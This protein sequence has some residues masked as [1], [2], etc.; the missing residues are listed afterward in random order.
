MSTI[1]IYIEKHQC[2]YKL[3]NINNFD[4]SLKII[5]QLFSIGDYGVNH[6]EFI[7]S[8]ILR[9]LK[10]DDNLKQ[11][12]INM[13]MRNIEEINYYQ[14]LKVQSTNEID[15]DLLCYIAH[16]TQW[17]EFNDFVQ[18]RQKIVGIYNKDRYVRDICD[19]V[20]D[21]L[22]DDWEDTEFYKLL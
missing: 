14:N 16:A 1:L 18:H 13:M 9:L 21:A 2:E 6:L 15:S 4:T 12:F 3:N 17:T 19:E 20:F 11:Y 10:E 8:N 5:N 22:K 7:F